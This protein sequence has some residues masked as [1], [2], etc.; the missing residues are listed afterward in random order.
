MDWG[1]PLPSPSEPVRYH[2]NHV[3][4]N[5]EETRRLVK[6]EAL[7]QGQLPPSLEG[8]VLPMMGVG[9]GSR[10]LLSVKAEGTNGTNSTEKPEE[11][12]PEDLFTLEEMQQGFVTFYILGN[13]AHCSCRKSLW[14]FMQRLKWLIQTADPVNPRLIS[15]TYQPISRLL[16]MLNLVNQG[17][18]K[19]CLGSE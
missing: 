10:R 3:S 18:Q 7:L 8:G 19:S 13:Y 17:D 6:R 14:L 5:A 4:Y 16:G 15:L 12:F 2:P 9:G 11:L 1:K